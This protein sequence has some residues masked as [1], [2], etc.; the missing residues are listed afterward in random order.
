MTVLPVYLT[1][2]FKANAGFE[3]VNNLDYFVRRHLG[4]R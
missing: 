2:G 4:G 1:E 3:P